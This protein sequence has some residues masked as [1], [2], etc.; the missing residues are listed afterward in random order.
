MQAEQGQ[1]H[2]PERAE[3]WPNAFF[4]ASKMHSAVCLLQKH[5]TGAISR[6][7]RKKLNF[8]IF[9]SSSQGFP[10]LL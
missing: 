1:M 5:A 6:K 10:L 9:Q 2:L 3:P 7:E 8:T 4:Q